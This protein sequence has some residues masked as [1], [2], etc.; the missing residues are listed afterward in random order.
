VAG[1]AAAACAIGNG[2]ME[3]RRMKRRWL[4]PRYDASPSEV[5]RVRRRGVPFEVAGQAPELV[6]HALR[7]I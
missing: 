1:A 5:D 3:Q 2:H 4:Q 7:S 6:Q